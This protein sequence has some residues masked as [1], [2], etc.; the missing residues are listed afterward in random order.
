[1]ANF[2]GI[3]CCYLITL[4]K[5]FYNEFPT[6]CIDPRR[7]RS[8]SIIKVDEL[9]TNENLV[10]PEIEEGKQ[11]SIEESKINDEKYHSKN[12]S[13][14]SKGERFLR[15]F[16]VEKT[17]Y[18]LASENPDISSHIGEDFQRTLSSLR[19]LTLLVN[20]EEIESMTLNEFYDANKDSVDDF[21]DFIKGDIINDD[22]VDDDSFDGD[23]IIDD[24][25]GTNDNGNE[26]NVNVNNK[27]K[28]LDLM[29]IDQIDVPGKRKGSL[30]KLKKAGAYTKHK[31]HMFYKH[32]IIK[33]ITNE[34]F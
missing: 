32:L 31:E 10:L 22:S 9:I 18:F 27:D 11:E 8:D 7:K 23:S 24:S 3:P 33:L 6:F 30:T 16:H 2:N 29:V 5:H 15:L 1:M 25:I 21:D 13:N 19:S 17:I 20:Y 34:E 26:N 4:Y 14:L 28:K 12:Y